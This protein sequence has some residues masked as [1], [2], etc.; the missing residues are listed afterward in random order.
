VGSS[1]ILLA[2]IIALG[3]HGANDGERDEPQEF[4]LDIDLSVEVAADSL[5]RTVDYRAIAD[6]ARDTVAE[7]SF[8]LLESLAESVAAAIYELSP[9]LEVTVT[10]HKPGAAESMGVDD[11][12]VEATVGP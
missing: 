4:A 3:N 10:V 8:V 6:L 2:G 9:V 5:D 7:T 11:V 1:R 12:A